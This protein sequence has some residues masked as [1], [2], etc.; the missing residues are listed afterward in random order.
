VNRSQLVA[1]RLYRDNDGTY[2]VSPDGIGVFWF[3]TM[4]EVNEQYGANNFPKVYHVSH[5]TD[6]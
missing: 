1:D 6:F 5:L 2:F 4:E 3:D